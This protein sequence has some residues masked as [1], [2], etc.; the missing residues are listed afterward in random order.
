MLLLSLRL[1]PTLTEDAEK[2]INAWL[3]FAGPSWDTE[4][5]FFLGGGL[6]SAICNGPH[7]HGNRNRRSCMS[8]I[9]RIE[10]NAR[11]VYQGEEES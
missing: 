9:A 6:G 8:K 7:H 10:V 11:T 4:F 3:C 1:S 2:E 5:F